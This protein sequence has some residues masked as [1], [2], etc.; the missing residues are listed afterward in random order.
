VEAI[1]G[2]AAAAVLVAPASFGAIGA[3]F[4]LGLAV[5]LVRPGVASVALLLVT[6]ALGNR[7]INLSPEYLANDTCKVQPEVYAAIVD[8]S[9]WLMTDVD[10]LFTRAYIWF[11]ENE[12]VQ[13]LNGCPV[14]LGHVSNSIATMASMSYVAR[15]FPLPALEGIPDA[16]IMALGTD[17]AILV[18]I[19]N[20]PA[21]RDAW[22]AR[23]ASLGLTGTEIGSRRVPLL[24]S[25][26]SM[27][28]W[29][30]SLAK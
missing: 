25:G 29:S 13:P 6:F 17:N 8:A 11:D 15:A 27:H 4:L 7:L 23:L 1:P 3:L 18:I 28:A 9:S 24:A 22:K 10:P 5:F 19:S 30:I 2:A 21:H 26:L 12:I 14:R 20:V 16:S